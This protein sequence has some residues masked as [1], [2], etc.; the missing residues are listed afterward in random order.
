MRS[1]CFNDC[2]RSVFD[3]R[4]YIV[5]WLGESS[6]FCP[7]LLRPPPAAGVLGVDDGGGS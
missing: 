3:V 1:S 2:V 4:H 6:T 7:L 5:R